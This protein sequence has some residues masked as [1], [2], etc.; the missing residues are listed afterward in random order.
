MEISKEDF[1]AYEEVRESGA[2]NMFDVRT[3]SSL[4][5]LKRETIFS[6][7]NNYDELSNK[8]KK[9]LQPNCSTTTMRIK[10]DNLTE[11]EINQIIELLEDLE[12]TEEMTDH[13][14]SE[15]LRKKGYLSQKEPDFND[16]NHKWYDT[17]FSQNK[18]FGI[19]HIEIS[20]EVPYNLDEWLEAE[21]EKLPFFNKL[22]IEYDDR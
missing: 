11:Q 4:S 1:E 10:T 19:P 8:Y 2:T 14:H 20:G 3:V 16:W 5:G 12:S 9:E 7:M 13:E 21:L 17:Y 18:I 22:F 6:I 15:W